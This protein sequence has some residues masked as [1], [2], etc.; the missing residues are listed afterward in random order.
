MIAPALSNRSSFDPAKRPGRGRALLAGLLLVAVVLSVTLAIYGASARYEFVY[1]DHVQI[2][3][4]PWLHD[5]D[6]FR[7]FLTRP[8]WGFYRDRGMVAS[9]YYR[10]AFGAAYSLIARACGISARAFHA[11]SIALHL[12]VTLLVAYGA[13]R[14]IADPARRTLGALA[15]SLLFAVY[16]AHAEAVAWVG[17]QADL[18]TALFALLALLAYLAFKDGG[19]R[20]FGWLGPLA[21]LLACL[22]KEPGTALLLVLGAVEVSEWRREGTVWTAV[23]RGAG[24]LAPYLLV[25]A[26]YFALR[27]NALGSFSPRSYEV[28]ASPAGAFAYAAGLLARYL[29][30][31]VVPFPVQLLA[32]I[33]APALLSPVALAG[34]AAA[35][36]IAGGLAAAA[37]NGRARREIV[38]PLAVIVAFVLPVLAANSIGGSNFAERYLYLPSAGLAWL[39]G[40]LCAW[41]AV[42]LPSPSPSKP[43]W[44]A[45][46]LVLGLLGAAGVAA[47]Q[48]AGLYR[49]DLT[50]FRATVR[51]SPDAE[52]AR[53]NLGMALYNRGRLDEAER[54]YGAALR[55][56]PYAVPPLANLGVLY[57][58]RGDSARA[59]S[60]FEAVLRLSPTHAIAAD[61]LARLLRA[62]GDRAGADRRLDALFAAGGENYEALTDRA[63]DYLTAGE[64]A[65]A[66][67][68]LARATGT[69]PEFARGW[70]LLARARAAQGDSRGAAAAARR[71]LA[72]D[73]KDTDAHKALKALGKSP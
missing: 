65:K 7:L 39:F 30:F 12:A 56:S 33:P 41:G 43:R 15:A 55:L 9:N 5:P 73:P 42:R 51:V 32:G 11:A 27:L 8:F 38:V 2:E 31:L 70:G 23:R 67:P 14:L 28:T 59:R 3:R 34:M 37:W 13:R 16:P 58:R 61:H 44:A 4:N 21:Y 6:G 63:E 26:L 24:R 52:I 69:F 60:T 54:E 50:L 1:D 48:R 72:I 17:G 19:W 10:P 36:A 57:E 35:A 66:L 22:A 25:L 62:Q 46:V 29:G 49:N 47:G 68:L 20:G 45:A 71:A 18:L 64:P 53:N 40:S